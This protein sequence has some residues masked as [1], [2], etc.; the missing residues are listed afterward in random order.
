[1]A[2]TRGC[3]SLSEA[4]AEKS[5]AEWVPVPNVWLSADNNIGY[6]VGGGPSP[7]SKS[8]VD[9]MNYSSNTTARVPGAD[10]ST[11]KNDN[12]CAGT[13]TEGFSFYGFNGSSYFSSIEK[14]EYATDTAERA[15]GNLPNPE[16]SSA[17]AIGSP[18]KAYVTGGYYPSGPIDGTSTYVYATGSA[19]TMPGVGSYFSLSGSGNTTHGYV[20]GGPNPN[21]FMF[22]FT[23]ASNSEA[24]LP[25]SPLSTPGGRKKPLSAASS[26]GSYFTG[27]NPGPMT[28]TDK[29]TFATD[30]C[31]RIPG[32]NAL[33][34]IA[35]MQGTGNSNSAYMLNFNAV[36]FQNLSYSTD[37]YSNLPSG[38]NLSVNR[39][40]SFGCVSGQ[41]NNQPEA[42]VSNTR[43]F[44]SAAAS[45]NF[46]YSATGRGS[47]NWAPGPA[48]EFTYK[49]DYG[50]DTSSNSPSA[51][52]GYGLEQSFGAGNKTTA[53]KMGGRSN[54]EP[55]DGS[56]R[57]E[58]IVY[59]TDTRASAPNYGNRRY[60]SFMVTNGTTNLIGTAGRGQ[61][62]NQLQSNCYK[63]T[64]S[65]ESWSPI[66]AN[67]GTN[68]T[69]SKRKAGA[70]LATSTH[71]YFA[72]GG[73]GQPSV[74]SNVDKFNFSND[75]QARVPGANLTNSMD[76]NRGFS[77]GDAGYSMGGLTGGGDY[78]SNI[79]K[80][81][82]STDTTAAFPSNL[83]DP[84]QGNQTMSS[85]SAGYATGGQGPSP[86]G[87]DRSTV[88]KMSFSTGTFSASGNLPTYQ[89]HGIGM[90]AGSDNLPF[91]APPASTPGTPS[92]TLT[93]PQGIKAEGYLIQG[94][95]GPTTGSA[96][97]DS[98][99]LD[100]T[101]DTWS[102]SAN[103]T[104]TRE[105]A[106]ATSTTTNT[107]I[108]G[109]T[110][111]RVDGGSHNNNMDKYTYATSTF[112]TIPGSDAGDIPGPSTAPK[113]SAAGNQTHGYWAFGPAQSRCSKLT[114]SSET[115]SNLPNLPWNAKWSVG[116]SMQTAGY[117]GA[118]GGFDDKF[119]SFVK[120][121]FSNDTYS[122]HNG[123]YYSG[124]GT[125]RNRCGSSSSTKAYIVGGISSPRQMDVTTWANNTTSNSPST[126]LASPGFYK[127]PG[128]GSN[129]AGYFTGGGNTG[130]NGTTTEKITYASDTTAIV[131]S[132]YFS[133][134]SP[135]GINSYSTGGPNMNGLGTNTPNI[136]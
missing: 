73:N 5:A 27:G 105:G 65:S 62:S 75:T 102:S 32:A 36:T 136:I 31:A 123:W 41:G 61:S 91:A 26:T 133:S 90:S 39:G 7:S 22:K 60:G 45:P 54:D 18:T 120:I 112:S 43:W 128:Q 24:Q 8:A 56:E 94:I 37:T 115:G 108:A 11:P 23:Y 52:V 96:R 44:D 68:T 83:P 89:H 28:T 79:D 13:S 121:A 92:T 113:K 47:S 95:Q 33:S 67:P 77:R 40:T 14:I 87:W 116:V 81:T 82:F 58:K 134:S 86:S 74:Y 12:T 3:W 130:N 55:A 53:Y 101:T 29:L 99:K 49:V 122:T 100:Y 70:T 126:F 59:A 109:G 51:K 118:G 66:P 48:M 124:S 34:G 80:I 106:G 4:W 16:R 129:E 30:A 85:D 93:G 135:S 1:M 35:Y 78:I 2:D 76:G 19:S 25:G 131:P 57:G 114:Y 50:T 97:S 21:S 127:A 72:G 98:Y 42:D 20:G 38:A 10:I 104:M 132:A 125:A 9:K 15:P 64:Y 119:T 117:Y 69:S 84:V 107:Y 71:G 103:S 46:G 6:W 111:A 88:S 110:M 63:M 17:C